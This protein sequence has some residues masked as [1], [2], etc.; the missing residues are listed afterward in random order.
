MDMVK[1]ESMGGGGGGWRVQKR[2]KKKSFKYN[3]YNNIIYLPF[4]SKE[5]ASFFKDT[6]ITVNTTGLNFYVL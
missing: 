6:L 4:S 5:K 3:K 1:F 2:K